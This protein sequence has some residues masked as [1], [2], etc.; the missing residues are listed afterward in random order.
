MM[1]NRGVLIILSVGIA[2][3]AVHA[4]DNM[5]TATAAM[6]KGYDKGAGLGTGTAQFYD[7]AP[8]NRCSGRKRIYK[9]S[10]ITGAQA[11]KSIPAGQKIVLSA[12]TNRYNSVIDLGS[13]TGVGVNT[14]TCENRLEFTPKAGETYDIIQRVAVG[15]KCELEVIERTSGLAP[16]DAI[17]I[18]PASCSKKAK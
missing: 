11:S 9:F 12:Y 17:T 4:K 10:P 18:N 3:L 5:P 2:G 6:E 1:S 14:G 8:D 15:K 13:P 7:Y 16:A